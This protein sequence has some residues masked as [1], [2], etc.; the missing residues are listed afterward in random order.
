VLSAVTSGPTPAVSKKTEAQY[1]SWITVAVWSIS[2]L[3]FVVPMLVAGEKV[4]TQMIWSIIA[5]AFGGSFVSCAL[6][7]VIWRV[8]ESSLP[9]KILI[10]TSAIFLAAILLTLFDLA[11][12]KLFISIQPGNQLSSS[13]FYRATNNFA[14]F[15]PHFSLLGALYALLAHNRQAVRR[16][17]MLADANSLAHQAKLSAL[18]YQLN[19]HFLFNTL[20]S[21]S[22]LVVTRRN[23]QA[24][25]MLTRL[26]EFLRTTLAVSPNTPQ[27][28]ESEL[29]TVE[30]Y[31]GIERIRFG[32]RLGLELCCPSAL[33]DSLIPH[34]LLQPLVENAIKYGVA[35]TED[36][37]TI[38]IDILE[39]DEILEIVVRNDTLAPAS[40]VHGI[41]VGLRNV[42]DRLQAV[43]GDLGTLEIMTVDQEYRAIVRF[44]RMKE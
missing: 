35:P 37:I 16:E 20:N 14:V 30:A 8:F 15:I 9:R 1:A 2:S 11:S 38:G 22:S 26:S 4:T 40:S 17:R 12:A 43:F 31:L 18:R 32:D 6:M 27:T 21:I 23:S 25:E 41:G 42:R 7:I 24:E 39:D 19:P 33:R 28:L 5:I 13:L 10:A 36:S 34:F 29:E 3:L 44:P